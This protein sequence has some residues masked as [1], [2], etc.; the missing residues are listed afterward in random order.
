MSPWSLVS[1]RT[2]S[3]EERVGALAGD[4]VVELPV[5]ACGLMELIE[6]WAAVEP[7]LQK[8]DPDSARRVQGAELQLPLRYPRKVLCSGTNYYAHMLEMKVSRPDAAR[9]YFFLKPPTTSLIGPGE[10][11]VVPADPAA[12]V[13]WEAELAVV[14][15]RRARHVSEADALEYVAGYSAINDVSLRGPHRVQHPIGEPFQW[16]W[17]AS[18]GADRS[19]PLGPGIRPAFQVADPQR[20]D[21]RLWVNGNLKQQA[22]TSDMIDEVAALIAAA[23]AI[24]TLEPGDVIATGTPDG[25]G[26]PR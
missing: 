1:Y 24:L 3:G 26:L 15:G 18:K 17:L 16:D 8:F 5:A 22:N 9:P 10:P 14:I 12:K 2:K 7:E 21:L 19:T 4:R 11:I 25:V 13:D 20:L 6:R 23:S